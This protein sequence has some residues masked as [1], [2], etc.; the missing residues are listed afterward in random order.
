MSTLFHLGYFQLN[1][2]EY[3]PWKV[4]CDSLTDDD[5][6]WCAYRIVETVEF[7]EVEGVPRGGLDLAKKLRPFCTPNKPLLIVDDV[8]TTGGSMERYRNG[9]A[10]I[11]FV[12]F[13][14][15]QPPSWI[16]ALWRYGI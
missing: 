14:R 10:A 2:G 4:E 16:R 8:L 5:L 15:Q 6:A 11:G 13:A 7:S 9:R 1:S 12:I 3:S